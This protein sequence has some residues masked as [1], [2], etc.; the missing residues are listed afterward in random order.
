[1]ASTSPV[2]RACPLLLRTLAL[3]GV[4]LQAPAG[5]TQ[6]ITPSG[7]GTAVTQNG[8]VYEIKGG[9]RAGS[10][11]FHSFGLFS[12]GPGYTAVFKKTTATVITNILGRV[13]GGQPSSIFGTID[14]RTNFPAANLFL[15]NPAGVIFGPTANLHVGGS[16]HVSTADSIRFREGEEFSLAT[17]E[18]KVR[19]LTTEPA[20]FGFLGPTAAPISI[21]GS[22]L[23]LLES[24]LG[25]LTETNTLSVVGGNIQITGASLMAPRGRIQIASVASAG[26]VP[27]GTSEQ[28]LTS[29]GRAGTVLVRGGQLIIDNSTLLSK[30]G[31]KAGDPLGIDLQAK[32]ISLA[33]GTAVGTETSGAGR[34]GNV[35]VSATG[36][37]TLT[38]G[39][40]I[41]S[42]SL[43]TGGGPGGNVTVTAKDS[44][45]ISGEKQGI[46]TQISSE[47]QSNNP[48]ARGGQ[49]V[50]VTPSLTMT[51]RGTIR[52]ESKGQGRGGDVVVEVARLRLTDGAEIASFNRRGRQGGGDVTVTATD[53]VDISGRRGLNNPSR[54][55]SG[56]DIPA[57]R[58]GT[59]SLEVG[60]LTLADGAQIASGTA[61]IGLAFQEGGKVTV[62]AKDSI[63]IAGQSGIS[64]RAF[65][66]DAGQVV[67]SAPTVTMDS[68]FIDTSTA[69][70]GKA[71]DVSVNVGNLTLT[72]GAQIASSSQTNGGRGGSVMVTATDSVS[73][74]GKSSTGVGSS[75]FSKDASSGLFSITESRSPAG[76]VTVSGPTLILADGGTISVASSNAGRA[77]DISLSASNFTL[78]GRAR[79]D[80]GTTSSGP[81][82]NVTVNAADS[83]TISGGSG[84]FS[85]A[86]G[87][88]PG[89]NIDLRA[90]KV[91]LT[92]GGIISA[93]SSGTGDAGSV[94]ITAAKSFRSQNSV[95]TTEAIQ[96]DGGNISF[97]GGP[98]SLV[99]LRKSQITTSV[100]SG[101][102]K[103]GNITID[104][105]FVI[106]DHSRIRADAFG[107]PGGNVRIVADVYLTSDSLVSA[108]SAL[109]VPGTVNIQA[110]I[111]NVSGSLARL[112]EAVLQAA[113]LLRASCAARLAGG[114]SSSLVLGGRDSV[115]PEPGGLLPSPLLPAGPL[116]DRLS[117]SQGHRWETLPG[118]SRTVLDPMCSR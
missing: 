15:I 78:T 7:L 115:P 52:T 71:G 109:G 68:G 34:A 89:G 5:Q 113:A 51:G 38:G 97:I 39:A 91:L 60:K 24:K 85:N 40:A 94:A 29:R 82:G 43:G 57:G 61:P 83:L 105:Q 80:S 118:F 55:F 106:L 93:K 117:R 11:L 20:A 100:E 1:M 56:S 75:P 112:P 86:A 62:T 47:T 14:T 25:V 101:K 72:R 4:M 67:I 23:E 95:V 33:N 74:S 46:P 92:N 77:G 2:L 26:E 79:V 58:T 59:I 19:T 116:D 30:T 64:S 87:K 96:A 8:R 44:I 65:S 53:V 42:R 17:T 16:F 90:G 21:V 50:I 103:G 6:T 13:T 10:N 110:S 37:L 70:F 12:V 41:Q 73:I 27:L 102:G 84:L 36:K 69:G 9:T 99:Y 63:V 49:L 76:R 66:R 81:G 35:S 28:A 88:G 18:E 111:T 45:E 48:T 108:S 104:P 32:D 114:K 3:V 22:K 54:I 31:M 98:G 107:G